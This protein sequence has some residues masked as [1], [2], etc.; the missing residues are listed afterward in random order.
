MRSIPCFSNWRL[1]A[2][3]A[4][5]AL[6][7]ACESKP[8][9]RRY[10]LEGRVVA[11]DSA[12]RL[13]SVA[14]QEV[15][16]L[17]PAMTMP[18]PVGRNA[19]WVFGKIAPGDHIHATLVMTDHVELQDI[20]FTKG[21]DASGDG[22]SE[23]RIPNA[24]DVVPDFRFVNQSGKTVRL[25]DYRGRPLLLTFVYTRCPIPDYCPRMSNNFREI[26]QKLQANPAM[27]A[28]SQVL[29]ASIDPEFDTP[30]VLHA[31]GT[32]YAGTVDPQFQHWQFATASPEEVRKAADFFGMSY[33]TKDGQ[34]VH[35][36][37]T[38]LIGADG[39]IVKVYSGNR[40]TADEV[41]HD[42][43]AASVND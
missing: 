14:H 1:V 3:L 15:L 43:V 19:D 27:Y 31:Y 42:Y 11:V 9:G 6:L 16:G 24:G 34:I 2:A 8:A 21:G 26:L 38:V 5:M 32:Q 7:T 37:R 30:K 35:N 18:F 20:S 12:S 22:T 13:I 33:N 23:L 25:A 40:W 36:L 39:K 17:M 29:T 28:K 41:A 4:L 10:E